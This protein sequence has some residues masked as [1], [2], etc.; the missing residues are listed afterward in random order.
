MKKILAASLI[1]TSIALSVIALGVGGTATTRPNANADSFTKG[2]NVDTSSA[3]VQLKGDPLSTYSATKPAPGKKIDFNSNTVKSYRAQLSAQRNDFKN[4]LRAYAP[5]AQVTGQYDISLN[6]VAVRLNGTPKSTIEQAPQAK[7]VAYQGIYYPSVTDP[8]LTLINAFAA[9]G[10]G[11]G[12]NAG[13]I[14]GTANDRIKVGVIDTGIDA[15]H[16]CFNDTGFPPTP[17]QGPSSLTNNKVIVAKVF[18]NKA[19]NLGLTPAA[20]QAHGTHVSGTVGCDYGVTNASTTVDG[21]VVGYGV[22]GVAPGAQLG[23][24]NV[25]PGT[26]DNARSED[27]LNA[28]EAAYADGMDIVNM[29]IGGGPGKNQAGLT[30]VGNQDLLTMAVDDLDQA[31]MISAVAAGNSGPNFFTI[32]SPGSAARA[33]TAG[34]VT[35]GH[36]IGVDVE[37]NTVSAHFGAA[38]GQFGPTADAT[39]NLTANLGT[40]CTGGGSLTGMI[41]LIDRGVCTFSTKIRNAQNAGAVGAIIVNN[42]FG[43]PISMAQ[44]GTANQPTIPGVMVSKADRTN[45]NGRA[46][47]SFTIHSTKT[48]VQNVPADNDYLAGFSSRGPTDV[49]F[50]VKPDITAPGVNVLSSIP[51]SGPE[52]CASPPCWAFF[53]GTSMATP[54]LAGS[55]AVVLGQ[56]PTWS[57]SSVRSAIVNTADSPTVKDPATGALTTILN[58]VGSGRENLDSA[59][60]AKVALDPVSV[61]FGAIPSVSGISKTYNVKVTNL[62]GGAAVFSFSVGASTG[63]GVSYSVTPSLSLAAGASGNLTVTMTAAQG[64]SLGFHDATLTITGGGGSAHAGVFTFVK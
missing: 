15:T 41:A 58:S 56:H 30:A 21:V 55:A 16:P 64:S 52:S 54:H 8:D 36:Y 9:W 2:P 4:W 45:L 3:I 37:D 1:F 48:Y 53:Q 35:V 12:A 20:V 29:S 7:Y 27:I 23:N 40:Y 31:G 11:G 19:A 17:Q 61:S 22:Q 5:K 34:A 60:N 50:R 47:H 33:L 63:T 42:V 13:K 49:D 44:D 18:N 14:S 51:N 32:E 38:V 46:G 59:V 26:M 57:S 62:S 24:Y 25:F 6:A 43:P 10:G 28:L 39:G